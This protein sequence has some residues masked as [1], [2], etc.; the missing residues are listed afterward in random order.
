MEIANTINPNPLGYNRVW[1]LAG[2]YLL[3]V[4]VVHGL[5]HHILDPVSVH[6][7]HRE[8]LDAKLLDDI[9]TKVIVK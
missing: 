7:G 2:L 1:V 6:L 9:S 3:W 5:L 4:K 8:R